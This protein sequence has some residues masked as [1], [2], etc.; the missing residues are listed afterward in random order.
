MVT[1]ITQRAPSTTAL[2]EP[3]APPWAQRMVLKLVSYFQ[4]LRPRAPV[5]MWHVNK[6]DLPPADDWPGALVLVAD[7]NELAISVGGAW[8]KV[9]STG[10]V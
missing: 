5:L 6:V 8:L 9:V 1:S 7:Q 3:D 2:V 10:P 4:P